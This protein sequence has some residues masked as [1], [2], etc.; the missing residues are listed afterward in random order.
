[1]K[2]IKISLDLKTVLRDKLDQGVPESVFANA[3]ELLEALKEL[4]R[5]DEMPPCADQSERAV[6]AMMNARATIAK[7]EPKQ[8]AA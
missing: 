2:R 5:A 3:P 7:V 6:L 1:M 4:L 8:V